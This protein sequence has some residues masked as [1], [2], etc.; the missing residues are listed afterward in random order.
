MVAFAAGVTDRVELTEP[1]T[2]GPTVEGLTVHV[3]FAGQLDT[4]SA[5]ELLN[6][7]FEVTVMVEFPEPPCV[8]VNEAG[9][10]DIEKSGAA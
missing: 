7:N 10:A 6:P 4:V 5:T 3:V 8:S 9:L 1:F 2:G